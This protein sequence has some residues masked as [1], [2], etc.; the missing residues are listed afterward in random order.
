MDGRQ[1]AAFR[2]VARTGS[3]TRAAIELGYSQS[4][5]TAQIK[6]LEAA[7]HVQLFDRSRNGVRLT[8]SGERFMPY[9][10]RMLKLAEEAMASVAAGD[11][12]VSGTLTIGANETIT[13]YRLPLLVKRFHDRYPDVRLS[14]RVFHDGPY[15]LLKSVAQSEI[16]VALFHSVA[17]PVTDLESIRI[18]DEDMA[19]IAPAGHPLEDLDV[20]AATELRRTQILITRTDCIY[21][22]IIEAHVGGFDMQDTPP[23][24]FGTLEAVKN[25]VASARLGVSALPRV[26]V[27]DQLADAKVTELGWTSHTSV[28]MY[29]TWQEKLGMSEPLRALVELLART[30]K[31]QPGPDRSHA[32]RHD[33]VLAAIPSPG[34]PT[35]ASALPS[36][37]AATARW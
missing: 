21:S 1:L 16:D 14:L 6:S 24:Q 35:P 10:T 20:V 22:R 18:M 7:L 28:G 34:Q 25:A 8:P 3:V 36:P 23:L 2:M 19:L 5:V 9:A 27:S 29:A 26:A 32:E 37:A 30:T 15:S 12:P 11:R 4:A 13:T 31:R 17:E 33:P